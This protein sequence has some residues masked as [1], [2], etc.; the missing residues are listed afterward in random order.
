MSADLKPVLWRLLTAPLHYLKQN[1]LMPPFGL[2]PLAVFA[3]FVI[4]F[5]YH[6]HSPFRTLQLADPDD[7]MRLDEVANWLKGQS[8]L[9]LGQPRI[10]PSEHV[11]VHWARLVDIPLAAVALPLL[12]L[13]GMQNALLIASFIVPLLLFGI[14]LVLVL[15][16]AR[17]L[18][19]AK[20]ANCATVMLLFAPSVLFNFSPGRADH[21]AYEILVGGFGLLCLE[22]MLRD[23]K[24]WTFAVLSAAAFA[25]GLWIGT[26]ALPWVALFAFALA[27][28][29]SWQGGH[30][31]RN[32]A[33]FGLA[34]PLAVAIVMPLALAPEEFSSRALSWF[35]GADLV[36]AL[37]TGGVFIL[38]WAIAGQ[39]ENKI[40]RLVLTGALGLTAAA[41]F[42]VYMP[43]IFSGAYADYDSFFNDTLLANIG[44]AQPLVA[45]LHMNM[46]NPASFVHA[47][48]SLLHYAFLPLLAV[49][50]VVWNLFHTRESKARGL[51]FARG[52]F[53]VPALILSLFWQ[54][55]VVYFAELF[56]I[57]PVTW[58]LWRGWDK[59]A[60]RRMSR[61]RFWA[62]IA[63]FLAIAPL[64][65]VLVPALASPTPLYP[66]LILFPA[67][68][69][70]NSCPLIRAGEFLAAKDGYGNK[71]RLILTGVNEGPELLFRTPHKVLAAAYNV[72]GNRDVYDFFNAHDEKIA[73][74]ILLRRKVDLVLVCRNIPLFYAGLGD[75]RARLNAEFEVGKDGR[76]RLVSDRKHPAMIEKLVNG[77]APGWLK[78]VVIPFDQDYLLFEVRK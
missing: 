56:A 78:P 21:H 5:L 67:A 4:C 61:T 19:G 40:W 24:G 31:L 10:S 26:E 14:L 6:P 11:I 48:P 2:L 35:S 18:M 33:V 49:L 20:R 73:H 43:E 17:P 38:S 12:A 59:L 34:F 9:D 41:L 77:G 25:C 53:L 29:S 60:A 62:E 76:V 47:L 30:A 3:F 66:D 7:Y 71:S 57:A 37:L 8:W 27:V 28:L 55:R 36:F 54:V 13:L 44:E 74:E 52:V 22:R 75:F 72:D 69:P 51:W 32:A 46:H 65:V 64:P 70:A 58:L 15:A 45:A 68:R 16:L 39:L 63:L 50:V 23:G 42:L 1:L